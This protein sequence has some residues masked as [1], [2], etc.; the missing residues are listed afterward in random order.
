[1]KLLQILFFIFSIN[2]SANSS[3][4][5]DH[6]APNGFKWSNCG[7]KETNFLLPDNWFLKIEKTSQIY[8]VFISK[9]KIINNEN[10]LTGLTVN[11]ITNV[12]TISKLKPT[13]YSKKFIVNFLS[14]IRKHNGKLYKEPQSY[15][16]G[17]FTIYQ[18]D[19]RDDITVMFHILLANDKKDILYIVFFEAPVHSWENDWKIGKTIIDNMIIDDEI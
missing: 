1:M 14:S 19:S 8:A 3:I 4:L 13:E 15:I 17:D 2:I 11:A 7:P 6:P 18:F 5:M 9:E 10:F 12:N 16:N